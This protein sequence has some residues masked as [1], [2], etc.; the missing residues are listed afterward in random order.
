MMDG[1]ILTATTRS[2][3]TPRQSHIVILKFRGRRAVYDFVCN[4]VVA[5]L[6]DLVCYAAKRP[7]TMGLDTSNCLVIESR[8]HLFALD[9]SCQKRERGMTKSQILCRCAT[10]NRAAQDELA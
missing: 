6:Y 4:L 10:E 1:W 8:P 5:Y 9:Q 2:P 3:S 7:A